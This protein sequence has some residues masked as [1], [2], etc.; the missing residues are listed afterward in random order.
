MSPGNLDQVKAGLE[1]F[2]ADDF[3]RALE[4]L[5]GDFTWDTTRPASAQGLGWHATARAQ[6]RRRNAP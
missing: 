2:N 1:A 4:T 3:D 6:T 5:S